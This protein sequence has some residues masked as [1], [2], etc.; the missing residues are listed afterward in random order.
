MCYSAMVEQRIKSL[1]IRFKARIDYGA[2][3]DL[4]RRRLT[5]PSIKIAR[6]L[7]DQFANPEDDLHRSIWAY[8]ETYRAERA[9]LL[10]QALAQ[11]R[12]RLRG[13]QLSLAGLESP[14]PADHESVVTKK[15]RALDRQ[16]ENL[17]RSAPVESDSRIF[18]FWYFPAVISRAGERVIVPVRYH[19]RLAAEPA[20][21][22]RRLPG[23]Y[24]AR[25]DS[26]TGYWKTLFGRQH[27]LCVVQR[28]F[29]H[30]PRHRYQKRE[31]LPGEVGSIVVA[32][33]PTGVDDLSVACLWDEWTAPDQPSLLS[34]ATI[35]DVPPPD[36]AATGHDR[37]VVP[38]TSE[39][40]EHWLDPDSR[41]PDQLRSLLDARQVTGFSHWQQD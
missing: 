26:L 29:E 13:S 39:A 38:L 27:A 22:D 32:Y 28:F 36:V 17:Q 34:L 23:L 6:A 16:V 4:F 11:Q 7:E 41:G 15:I 9:R 25:R 24:N 8:I 33:Q 20:D 37:F 12:K 18:P 1:G 35:T 40:A 30:V 31:P 5:D 19:C 2:F 21:V 3:A 10:G 14:G